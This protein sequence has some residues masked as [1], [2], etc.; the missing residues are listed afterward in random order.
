LSG[1]GNFD[2]LQGV[3]EVQCVLEVAE[4]SPVPQPYNCKPCPLC[5]SE[6]FFPLIERPKVPVLLNRVYDNPDD[7]RRAPVGKLDIVACKDC[8]F[9]FNRAFQPNL[10]TYDANYDNDQTY[11][12][13]FEAHMSAMA[14]RVLDSLPRR[15]QVAILEV[16]CGQGQFLEEL[17]KQSFG[18]VATC[19]GCDPAWRGSASLGTQIEPVPFDAFSNLPMMTKLD[20][21]VCRHVIE[22]VPD[23]VGFL[24]AIR[25]STP[26]GWTGRVF[27]ETPSLEWILLKDAYHDFYYEHCNYFSSDALR[28]ALARAGFG[29]EVIA[30]VFE[31]QYLVADAVRGEGPDTAAVG[32]GPL[33]SHVTDLRNRG[34]CFLASWN[35]LFARRRMAEPIAIWGA[36]AK[37]TTFAN[38]FDPN[39]ERISC[40]IDINPAKQRR[41]TPVTAHPICSPSEAIERE[42]KTI[43]VMNPK[44]KAEIQETLLQTGAPAITLLDV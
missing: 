30:A 13:T 33:G 2:G 40:L 36:A 34:D 14:R 35:E 19:I 44:Y 12:Q 29:T 7:A 1:I 32:G 42:V 11:S 39:A 9:V 10:I 18:R 28:L 24:S 15:G 21:I 6:S 8:H 26:A 22:H 43:I 3:V 4:R 17:Q 31:G 20:A 37:G 23:P 5:G 38:M 27:L 25:S 41:F 16:G